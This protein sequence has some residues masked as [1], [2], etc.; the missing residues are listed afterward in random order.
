MKLALARIGSTPCLS[1]GTVYRV[2]GATGSAYAAERAQVYGKLVAHLDVRLAAAGELGMIFMDG[3]G[4]E[5][6]Y[7]SAH[8]NLKLAYRHVIED[9]LFQAS[10]RNQWVQMADII[11]W[12][13]YQKV[14]QAPERKFAWDWY[15]AHL[16]HRDVNGGPLAV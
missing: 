7:F 16:L 13:A 6:A 5:T 8:R 1:V 3:D 10:H 15:D 4:S 12:S 14:R 2:T 9:P 11:A